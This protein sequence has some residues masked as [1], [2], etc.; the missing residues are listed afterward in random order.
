VSIEEIKAIKSSNKKNKKYRIF[1][2]ISLAVIFIV[3]G[4]LSTNM[5]VGWLY[6]QEK[7][8]SGTNTATPINT[9]ILPAEMATLTPELNPTTSQD[10]LTIEFGTSDYD[11]AEKRCVKQGII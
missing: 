8:Q 7:S 4:L 10:K 5:L 11:S 1:G 2:C 9:T 6:F 3:L